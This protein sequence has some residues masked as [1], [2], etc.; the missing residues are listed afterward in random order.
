M[1]V[2]FVAAAGL[3]DAAVVVV[4]VVVG[5]TSVRC[6]HAARSAALAK[7]QMDLF[8]IRVW[9][10]LWTN[11]KSDEPHDSALPNNLPPKC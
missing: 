5:A 7:M 10:C 9:S 2:V 8:M 6:S 4:V 3:G 1:I 11:N